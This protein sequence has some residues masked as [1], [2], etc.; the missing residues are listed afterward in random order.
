M[1]TGRLA[2]KTALVT[3][4]SSGI[5]RATAAAFLR[6]GAAV[7][8]TGT[9]ADALDAL[10]ARVPAGAGSLRTLAGD[11]RDAAFV[12]RLAAEAGAV[13]ILANNAGVLTYAPILD[14]TPEQCDA[15]FGI[16]VLGTLR[17]T[18]AIAAGMVAR[19]RGHIVMMTSLAAREIYR[20][21]SV[22]CATKHALAALSDG[23]RLELQVHG[24]K[25]TEVAPGMVDTDM[26]K[27]ITHPAVLAAVGARPY[28]PLSAEEVAEAVVYAVTAAPNLCADLIELRPQGAA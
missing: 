13:D 15:M 4:A 24:I 27:G 21:G 25:V 16:N 7:L 26:R 28:K 3:G 10:A 23:L 8:A 14:L 6:E 2:G 11:L 18:Q 22:Y 1:T 5:G 9:R 17:L 20:F 12:Q 19:K